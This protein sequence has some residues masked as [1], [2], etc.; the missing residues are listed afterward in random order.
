MR[1]STLTTVQTAADALLIDS[2]RSRLI[3]YVA[4]IRSEVPRDLTLG[5]GFLRLEPRWAHREAQRWQPLETSSG[6]LTIDYVRG[7]L[8]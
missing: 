6:R 7:W 2:A 8:R 4:G 1:Q 5:H 3:A